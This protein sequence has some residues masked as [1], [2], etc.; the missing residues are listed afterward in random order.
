MADYQGWADWPPAWSPDSTRLAF[1]DRRDDAL[2]LSVVNA[3]GSG[4]RSLVDPLT[5]ADYLRGPLVWSPDGTRIAFSDGP[6]G[7]N[8]VFVIDADGSNLH[9]LTHNDSHDHAISWL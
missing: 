4:L 2:A 8:E 5:V 6:D 3:D 9:Q 7:D 1:Y